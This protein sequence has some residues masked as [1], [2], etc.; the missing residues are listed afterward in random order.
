M[1]IAPIVQMVTVGVPPERAFALFTGSM[2]RWWKPTMSIGTEPFVDVVVEPRS[3]GRWFE[4][5][6]EGNETDWGKVLAWEP[7]GRVLLGWQLD[8]GFKLDPNLITEV[9]VTFVPEGKGTRVTLIHRDLERD[10]DSAAR[11]AALLSGGWPTLV[12]LYAEFTKRDGQ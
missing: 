5:D 9:E 2:G 1:S 4:R 11:V 3:S 10:G 6:A 12:E 8:A 7:P